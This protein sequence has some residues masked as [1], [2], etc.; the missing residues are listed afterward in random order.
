MAST[1]RWNSGTTKKPALRKRWHYPLDDMAFTR[2]LAMLLNIWGIINILL[3]ITCIYTVS[4]V[5]VSVSS[6]WAF[7]VYHNY[8]TLYRDSVST[9]YRLSL[10]FKPFYVKVLPWSAF[11]TNEENII[12][13]KPQNGRKRLLPELYI[14]SIVFTLFEA[15][16]FL[17]LAFKS[18][19]AECDTENRHKTVFMWL[20]Y[21]AS[22]NDI[23]LFILASH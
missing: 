8:V 5:S 3:C 16:R 9:I 22:S 12:Y 6:K 1:S 4:Q 19:K 18:R 14:E 2:L 20:A 15:L 10:Q 23:T 13:I 11:I 17:Q 21:P 7:V